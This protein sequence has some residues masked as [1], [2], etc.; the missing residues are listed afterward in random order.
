M[1]MLGSTWFSF[2]W[3]D[4]VYFKLL[5]SHRKVVL[6]LPLRL[7]QMILPTCITHLGHRVVSPNQYAT[8]QARWW[9]LPSS[10]FDGRQAATFTTTPLYR[11]GIADLFRAWTS[12]ALIWLFPGKELPITAVN[13]C[14]C[15]NITMETFQ[16]GLCPTVRYFSSV[17]LYSSN[18]GYS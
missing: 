15:K 13:V 1:A 6:L 12:N 2:R 4:K 18:D 16:R 14:N 5:T 3:L 11:G 10:Y 8:P 9:V 17:P 7:M